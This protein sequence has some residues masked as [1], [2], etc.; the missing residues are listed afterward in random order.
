MDYLRNKWY[1]SETGKSLFGNM[2]TTLN[3]LKVKNLNHTR[4]NLD[5]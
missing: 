4:M 1:L 3:L 5:E 2:K